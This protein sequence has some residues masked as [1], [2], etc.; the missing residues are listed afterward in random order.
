MLGK[1]IK[2]AR[3]EKN[4]TLIELANK[5]DISKGHLSQIEKNKKEPSWDMLEKISNALEVPSYILHFKSS[6]EGNFNDDKN[7]K[8]ISELY[9]KMDLFAKEVY[10]N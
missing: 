4:I 2:E 7:R 5:A 1:T 6:K 3:L 8:K 10:Q 9:E